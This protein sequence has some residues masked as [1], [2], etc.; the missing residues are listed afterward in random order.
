MA[1]EID[2]HEYEA[3]NERCPAQV[4]LQKPLD[5]RAEKEDGKAHSE[6]SCAAPGERGQHEAPYPQVSNARGQRKDRI[7]K[8]R[9]SRD[10]GGQCS[11]VLEEVFCG[12]DPLLLDEAFGERPTPEPPY[13]VGYRGPE[14]RCYRGDGGVQDRQVRLGYR[15]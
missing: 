8:R 7:R 11:V 12:L 14:Y 13:E 15:H 10:A 4:V 6:K 3:Q 5:G 2:P 9:K 1:R